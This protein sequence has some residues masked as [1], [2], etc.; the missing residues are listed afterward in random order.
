MTEMYASA[1]QQDESDYTDDVS[2]VIERG[3]ANYSVTPSYTQWRKDAYLLHDQPAVSL[4]KRIKMRRTDGM[5]RALANLVSLPVKL[6]LQQGK[7]VAPPSGGAEEEVEFAQLMWSLPP[8][9][10]GMTTP[11]SNIIDQIL[12]STF[13]GHAAFELVS[14]IPTHG[15]LKGKKTLRKMAYRDPRTIT[16]LQD[17]RGGYAGF[18]QQVM[19]PSRKL[20][21]VT[22]SPNKT[23]LFTVNGHENPLYGISYFEACYPH[24]ESKMRVYYMAEMAAQFAAIPARVG[25]VPRHAKASEVIAFRQAL[26]NMYFNTTVLHKE[27][28][29]VTPFNS[30]SNFQFLQLI[31]H[32]NLMM[33]KAVLASFMESEQ[34]TVLVENST[35]DASAD[36]F[37]L[38]M[39]TLANEYASVL[40]NHVMPK[41]IVENFK[42]SDKFP[43]FKPGPLSDNARRKISSLFEKVA[44]SGILNVTPE[45][46]RELEKQVAADLGLDV[47]YEDIER[48]EEEAAMQQAE[49]AEMLAAQ[50]QQESI[51]EE[52]AAE[53]GTP[54]SPTPTS[55][56]TRTLATRTAPGEEGQIPEEANSGVSLS[57]VDKRVEAFNLLFG[58]L[59]ELEEHGVDEGFSSLDW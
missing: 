56:P 28:W 38:S 11:A 36:L 21:D 22:L 54:N 49:Q 48:R 20:L 17:E 41:Y 35:Q 39:E 8:A 42:G 51:E 50:A 7:W 26:E 58:E 55:G 15:P 19:L 37:L 44:V 47:D 9:S 16:L 25:Q 29:G 1:G 18:R 57:E 3:S 43:V 12:L 10:G 52:R 27:G 46:V 30:N 13:D 31:E 4:E 59:P 33:S 14:H 45:M 23:A 53:G 2:S 34:R 40:T 6:A 32:H 24:Y 5:A